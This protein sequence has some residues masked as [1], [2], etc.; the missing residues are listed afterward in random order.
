MHDDSC[1]V[2]GDSDGR[3]IFWDILKGKELARCHF[4]KDGTWAVTA[5]DGRYD[6][7]D[8]GACRHLRWTVGSNSYPITKFK[9]MHYTPTLLSNIMNNHRLQL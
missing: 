2:S 4:F 7:S 9:D 1:I 3:L 8:N 6:S 5:P